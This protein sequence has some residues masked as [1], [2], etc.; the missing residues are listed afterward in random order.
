MKYIKPSVEVVQL[1]ADDIVRTSG[2]TT[3]T[4]PTPNP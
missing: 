1:S 4:T 2:T 3:T